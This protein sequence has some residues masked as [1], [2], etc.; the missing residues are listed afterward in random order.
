[1]YADVLYATAKTTAKTA[2][3]KELCCIPDS[4][5]KMYHCMDWYDYF[6]K[7]QNKDFAFLL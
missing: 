7:K 4:S 2:A 1:L 3:L 5:V 6:Q